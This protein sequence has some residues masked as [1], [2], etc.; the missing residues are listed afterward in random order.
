MWKLKN[1]KKIH[2]E[3]HLTKVKSRYAKPEVDSVL[4]KDSHRI[5]STQAGFSSTY[6]NH[7]REHTG[8]QKNTLMEFLENKPI[9]YSSSNLA[10]F[11]KSFGSFPTLSVNQCS[12]P[13][14]TLAVRSSPTSFNFP[15]SLE[16]LASPAAEDQSVR[17]SP[18]DRSRLRL[19]LG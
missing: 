2:S 1:F 17:A 5:L 4:L 18:K 19:F 11:D 6:D 13:M 12:A 16:L 8:C 9:K 14:N 15:S 10:Q 7:M 3:P